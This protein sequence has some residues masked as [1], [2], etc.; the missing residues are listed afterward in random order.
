MNGVVSVN[1]SRLFHIA[2]AVSLCVAVF[3]F[4]ALIVVLAVTER[5]R[6]METIPHF[7]V[8]SGL[9][10]VFALTA[11]TGLLASFPFALATAAH[12]IASFLVWE[13]GYASMIAFGT[14]A[15]A[16][17]AVRVATGQ[18]EF[19]HYEVHET[20]MFDDVGMFDDGSLHRINP[21]SGLPMNGSLD[22]A[23]N[24]FGWDSHSHWD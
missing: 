8:W 13:V 20:D 24:P 2:A 12:T 6:L 23:G 10:V 16:V 17:M 21:A 14:L 11:V 4:L 22:I 7:G 5:T 9:K 19:G 15:F 18:I 1:Y 3:T